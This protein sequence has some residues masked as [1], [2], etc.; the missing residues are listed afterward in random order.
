MCE[1]KDNGITQLICWNCGYYES[2]SQA[3]KEHPEFFQNIVRENPSHF[4][5]R[6]LKLKASDEFLQRKKSDKDFTEP[7]F[8]L[9]LTK[10]SG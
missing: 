4:I 9:C 6:F 7:G 8:R 5:E 2:D 3:Y 1:Y 10:N